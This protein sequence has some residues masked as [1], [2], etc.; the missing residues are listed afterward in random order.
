MNSAE[1]RA[2]HA[3]ANRESLWNRDDGLPRVHLI[4][5]L[6]LRSTGPRPALVHEH[7]PVCSLPARHP[8]PTHLIAATAHDANLHDL[9]RLRHLH[10]R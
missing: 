6:T 10:H 4:L 9:L 8:L 5:C 3:E 2:Q 1:E 7:L